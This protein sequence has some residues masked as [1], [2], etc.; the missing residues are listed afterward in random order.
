M[1]I[2][3][4]L[5]LISLVFFVIGLS[6]FFSVPLMKD[7]A[8]EAQNKQKFAGAVFMGFAGAILLFL[9]FYIFL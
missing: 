4:V 3:K 7:D 1:K 2:E 5:A 8:T 6:L 9:V